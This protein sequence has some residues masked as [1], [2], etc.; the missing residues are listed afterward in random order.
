MSALYRTQCLVKKEIAQGLPIDND[1]VKIE[2]CG[3]NYFRSCFAAN[4]QDFK[5]YKQA[6]CFVY[7]AIC[8]SHSGLNHTMSRSSYEQYVISLCQQ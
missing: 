5:R 1:D 8:K 7:L 6:R 2:K 4:V 3:I